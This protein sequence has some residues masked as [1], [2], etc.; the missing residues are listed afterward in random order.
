MTNQ[1]IR[2]LGFTL[3]ELMIAVVVLLGVMVAVGRIFSTTSDV[4]ASGKAISETLQQAVAIEQQL[5]KDIAKMSREGFLGIRSVALANNMRGN[6]W[7]IDDSLPPNAIIR[8]DQLIFFTN[9]IA[10]SMLNTG[11]T[12]LAG[13]GL[14][15]MIY[16]GHG[17]RLE[18]LE[19]MNEGTNNFDE[20]DDPIYFGSTILTPW[21][22]GAIDVEARYYTDSQNPDGP[23]ERFVIVAGSQYTANGTQQDPSQWTLLRQAIVLGDDDQQDPGH[24]AKTSYLGRGIASNTIFPWDPRIGGAIAYPQL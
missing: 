4:S 19:G 11:N 16:Y 14:A 3:I 15:S 12:D 21:Y 6:F 10:S 18:Q 23:A 8:C 20:S 24:I 5:R 22:E 17:I 9:G 7:L 2:H 1:R 13:Q